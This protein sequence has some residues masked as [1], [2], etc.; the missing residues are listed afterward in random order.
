MAGQ[1]ISIPHP[2]CAL[3][4]YRHLLREASY[5]P[6]VCR[7]YIS[8]QITSRFR[9]HR[10]DASP[11][12]RLR[13]AT[14][15]L[16]YIRAAN[17]G[18][19]PRMRRILYL[20]FGRI[21][22]R[23]RELVV[24]LVSKEVPPDTAAL[25]ELISQTAATKATGDTEPKD[26]LAKWD[27]PKIQAFLASQARIDLKT[28]PR[29]DL[30]ATQLNPTKKIPTE[31][32]WG[33][34]LH[35]RLGRSK[36]RKAWKKLIQRTLP[37]ISQGEWDLLR[38]LATGEASGPEWDIPV[39]RRAATVLGTEATKAAWDWARYTEKPVRH[40]ERPNSRQFKLLSGASDDSSLPGLAP[41]NKNNYTTR[42]WKRLYSHVW[43]MTATMEKKP[44][45]SGWDVKWGGSSGPN[46][47]S[48]S[49]GHFEFF[50]GVSNTDGK[51]NKA[52]N[53]GEVPKATPD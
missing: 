51:A 11:S 34:P 35:P 28:S 3:H 43:E 32:I 49:T 6:P 2:R 38:R 39:R 26:W 27:L 17:A 23:R 33:N 31:N 8:E 18:D 5:L 40:V 42:L 44:G 21:G 16:R 37:P 53:A 4:L 1:A 7:P 45:D 19:L 12:K 30:K 24:S 41:I 25:E 13:G 15:D 29:P 20:T 10:D 47:P 52:K 9:K 22:R 46:L 36:L 48:A 50:Q 14:H